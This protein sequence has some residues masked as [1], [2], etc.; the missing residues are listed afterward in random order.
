MTYK[1]ATPEEKMIDKLYYLRKRG[2]PYKLRERTSSCLIKYTPPVADEMADDIAEKKRF[3]LFNKKQYQVPIRTI[4]A[5]VK[6]DCRQWLEDM[7]GKSHYTYTPVPDIVNFSNKNPKPQ[8]AEYIDR[9]NNRQ[10]FCLP[11]LEAYQ[12]Q[13]GICYT[14]ES[15]RVAIEN[16]LEVGQLVY[17]PDVDAAY[18]T[19]LY[20]L[21]F[22]TY[23]TYKKY[24]KFKE[25][26][27]IAVGAMNS[28][29]LDKDYDSRGKL[30]KEKRVFSK[31]SSFRNMVVIKMHSIY[32]EVCKELASIN[33]EV[34]YFKTDAFL[35]LPGPQMQNK[36]KEVL[37]KH[38]L[39]YKTNRWK[40]IELSTHHIHLRST[41]A[42]DP[43]TKKLKEKILN[44]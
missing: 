26:R 32:N 35:V 12:R 41:H 29:Y 15:N 24:L 38:G 21:G 18:W 17:E 8:Y 34:Y 2:I 25:E 27:N 19:L 36:V 13:N 16:D 9:F 6:R 1:L 5:D 40:I 7:R 20:R 37:D 31:Y 3:Y 43:D 42:H 30:I 39:T 11:D 14:Q 33:K 28:S 4:C 22:I 44:Y 23:A 10:F